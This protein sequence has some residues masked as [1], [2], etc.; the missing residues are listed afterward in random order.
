MISFIHDLERYLSNSIQVIRHHPSV[1]SA[2]T[3]SPPLSFQH[4]PSP[5]FQLE[6]SQ[7]YRHT[8][9]IHPQNI[10][11]NT[12]TPHHPIRLENRRSNPLNPPLFR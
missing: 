7:P 11:Q 8:S 6:P 12:N 5:F 3:I 10:P 2:T 4:H 1:A 9:L